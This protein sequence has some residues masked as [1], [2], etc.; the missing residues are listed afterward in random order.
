MEKKRRKIENFENIDLRDTNTYIYEKI[1]LKRHTNKKEGL[2]IEYFDVKPNYGS[3]YIYCMRTKDIHITLSRY[4]LKKDLTYIQSSENESIHI[5]F[6]L[7]GEK[8]I[9]METLDDLFLES[10]ETFMAVI[11]NYKGCIKLFGK[12]LFTEIKITLPVTFLLAHGFVNNYKLKTLSDER[13]ILPITDELFS[14]LENLERKAVSK[15]INKIYLNAKVFELMALLL[16]SYKN[17]NGHVKWPHDKMLKKLY[18]IKQLITS[19]LNKNF[20]LAELAGQVGVNGHTLN[21]EFIRVFGCTVNEFSI[22]EKM[23]YAKYMLENT[24][25][26]VYQIAEEI[27]YKNATHFTAA[28]KR[29]TNLT[30]KVYRTKA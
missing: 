16:E 9:Q 20:S 6:M 3:G 27:G 22:A 24:Q 8:I 25:K 2:S 14:I 7:T 13:L 15:V 17:S 11:T 5:N 1:S 26:M 21:K 12:K 10:R 29:F 30:P 23:N 4:R 19:N 18:Q 28:F